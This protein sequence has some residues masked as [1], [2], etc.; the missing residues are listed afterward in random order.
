MPELLCKGISHVDHKAFL[1]CSMLHVHEIWTY[2]D[3]KMRNEE[4][5]ADLGNPLL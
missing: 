2:A 4:I 3:P 1:D 5:S